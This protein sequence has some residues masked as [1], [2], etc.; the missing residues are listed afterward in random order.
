M[1]ICIYGLGKN[2]IKTYYYLKNR[3]IEISCFGDRES[4]KQG[5][6]FDELYCY[7]YEHICSLDKKNTMIIVAI[8]KGYKLV[9]TF[10]KMGFE[11]VLEFYH[12]FDMY[13]NADEKYYALFDLNELE[14]VKSTIENVLYM[15]SNECKAKDREII[16]IL[17]DYK[18]R[19]R[20]ESTTGK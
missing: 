11:H 17:E 14:N 4:V 12:I 3:G 1:E 18:R 2:G 8:D 20:Y 19:N 13:R 6:V 15:Q 16:Q 10:Q 5:Y 9:E 7:S